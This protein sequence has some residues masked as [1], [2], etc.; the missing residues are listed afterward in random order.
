M[1]AV[2]PVR[3]SV[4]DLRPALTVG[5]ALAELRPPY[6]QEL[7]VQ[8]QRPDGSW[9]DVPL[10]PMEEFFGWARFHRTEVALLRDPSRLP[11]FLD[12]TGA[13]S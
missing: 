9:Q 10:H 7:E 3:G 12:R 11:R 8:M 1:R 4:G 6:S 5:Q 2:L 13:S